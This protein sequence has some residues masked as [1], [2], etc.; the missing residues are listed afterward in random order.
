MSSSRCLTS[1]PDIGDQFSISFCHPVV[2]VV[3]LITLYYFGVKH[4]CPAIKMFWAHVLTMVT[5][6]YNLSYL[7]DA[8]ATTLNLKKGS[9]L[10]F[11]FSF[12]H[13]YYFDDFVILYKLISCFDSRSRTLKLKPS[14]E[15]WAHLLILVL[16][17]DWMPD[18]KKNFFL[19][20]FAHLLC[21]FGHKIYNNICSRTLA[22][23]CPIFIWL[24]TIEP[25]HTLIVS[26]ICR[27][28]QLSR[29]STTK[30]IIL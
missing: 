16:D 25:N 20:N 2:F 6:I 24:A 12:D 9:L 13:A 5:I 26:M 23:F 19:Q 28:D 29:P 27:L 10:T 21:C 22:C 14:Q 15:F 8:R 30:S 1:E 4:G 7:T 3:G 17:L 11:V 18:L